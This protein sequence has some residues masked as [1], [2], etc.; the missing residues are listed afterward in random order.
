[1]I[2]IFCGIYRAMEERKR[3]EK[4]LP[5]YDSTADVYRELEDFMRIL[6]EQRS[7]GT[8]LCEVRCDIDD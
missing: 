1:M 2:M 5:N 3:E 7:K 6:S 8:N 4:D